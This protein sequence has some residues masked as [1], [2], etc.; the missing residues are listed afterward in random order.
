MRI[1]SDAHTYE[2]IEDWAKMPDTAGARHGW[3]HPGMACGADDLIF[4]FHQGDPTVLVFDGDGNLLRTID[5]KLSEGHGMVL[6]REGGT[7]HL[8]VADI[9]AKRHRHDDYNYPPDAGKVSGQVVKM[10]MDGKVV[11]RIGEPDLPIY[12]EGKYSPTSVAVYEER[13]GGNGDIWVADGYGQN[14]V[15]RYSRFTKNGQYIS[16]ING[17][18]GSGGPFQCPH[19]IWIDLRKADPELYIADRTNRRIQVYD[20]EGRFKRVFG[21]DFLISP[22]AFARQGDC[23]IVAELHARLAVLD[24]EDRLVC[25][26]GRNEEVASM[27][28]WPN[29]KGPDGVPTRTTRL[30]PGRFNSPHGIA[31]DSAGNIYVAEWLIGGRTIKLA[32]VRG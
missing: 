11:L 27:E 12:R 20:L 26:L 21:Q 23:L 7:E 25:L 31:T 2:W 1:G 29:M 10:T 22:S 4:T 19:S 9:G 24:P 13:F 28:G 8:W 16:S 32:R 30:E 15:Y 17:S 5:T 6:T 18:E 14:Y 3:A